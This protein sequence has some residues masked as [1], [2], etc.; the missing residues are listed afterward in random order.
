MITV[1][2]QGPRTA[3]AFLIPK[4]RACGLTVQDG[5]LRYGDVQFYGEGPDGEMLSIGVE[6]KGLTELC[7]DLQEPRFTGFQ[8]PG[9]VEAYDRRYLVIRGEHKRDRKTGHLLVPHDQG[10]WLPLRVGSHVFTYR[11]VMAKLTTV[12]EQAGF[13][14][15]FV[16]GAVH[17]VVDYLVMLH[18]WWYKGFDSHGSLRVFYVPRREFGI[19][20]PSKF[21]T[22]LKSLCPGIGWERTR[23]IEDEFPTMDALLQATKDDFE[24]IDGIGSKLAAQLH[25]ALR[26]A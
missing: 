24:E 9:M 21:R 15:Q 14:Y 4:L 3:S 17:E 23:A 2:T 22:A 5:R 25:N 8:V 13:H 6:L 20:K 16:S 10:R 26:R 11:E 19:R 7:S 1:D 12:S 18:S